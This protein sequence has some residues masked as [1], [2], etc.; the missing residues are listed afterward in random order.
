MNDRTINAIRRTG[1][2]VRA[3][4]ANRNTRE[5]NEAVATVCSRI[6]R[7]WGM[8]PRL[9]RAV[10]GD[11]GELRLWWQNGAARRGLRSNFATD[12]TVRGSRVYPPIPRALT[13]GMFDEDASILRAAIAM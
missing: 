3:R 8:T 9:V 10:K 12:H 1:E 5:D 4:F 6:S 11:D 13:R 2:L 7:S